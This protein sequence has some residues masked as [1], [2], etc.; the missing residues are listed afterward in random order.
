MAFLKF[1]SYGERR[2]AHLR[3]RAEKVPFVAGDVEKYSDAAIRFGARCREEPHTCGCHP[4]VRG[5]KVLYLE[6]ETHPAGDLLPD[7][8]GL[9]FSVSLH[10]Q[11]AGRRLWRTDYHPSLG[12]PV[13]GLG[14]GVLHELEAQT[15][16][17]EAD[18]RIVL[19]D[20]DG[21]EAEMHDA[22][23]GDRPCPAAIAHSACAAVNSRHARSGRCG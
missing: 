10:E 14:R 23:I 17:E 12:T 15:V 7:D 18:G 11:Q 5:L 6:E 2:L 8:D 1:H 19:A 9:V 4:R 22:S 16:H 20:H 13:V 3:M 21:N